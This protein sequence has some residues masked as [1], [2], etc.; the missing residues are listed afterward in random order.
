MPQR[1]TSTDTLDWG[2]QYTD[3]PSR[4]GNT[5]DETLSMAT[6]IREWDE[7]SSYPQDIP[8]S[9]WEA[10]HSTRM[11]DNLVTDAAEVDAIAA[12]NAGPY[13][14]LS[15]DPSISATGVAFAFVCPLQQKC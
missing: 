4:F 13:V 1:Y 6:A 5:G 9:V 8:A 7:Y 15:L 3:A 2:G 11:V 14:V 10:H 12:A